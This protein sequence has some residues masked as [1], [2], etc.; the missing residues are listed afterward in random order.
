[1]N[2]QLFTDAIREADRVRM[3]LGLSIYEPLNI[4]DICKSLGIDVRF[5][6]VN[7]EGMYSDQG[8]HPT[9]LL[10]NQRPLPRRNY[11]CAHELGHHRFGHGTRVDM[12]TDEERANAS[13]NNEEILVDSFAGA[14]LMP[15]AG[16][17]AEFIQRGKDPKKSSPL[18]FMIIASIFGVGYGT[19][20]THC[21]INGLIGFDRE[22]TLLKHSPAKILKGLLGK[23]QP[24]HYKILDEFGTGIPIDLEVSNLLILPTGYEAECDHLVKIGEVGISSVFKAVY[25]GITRLNNESLKTGCFV[26][27]QNKNYVGLAEYRHLENKEI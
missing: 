4:Y 12:M 24:T 5:V 7:M 16:L 17:Q 22:K 26:R 18:D 23:S 25:G 11:S 1:M 20:V 13:Y 14:L 2:H 19:I 9:I 10:S 6:N 3:E 21:R 15:L 8:H 27:I